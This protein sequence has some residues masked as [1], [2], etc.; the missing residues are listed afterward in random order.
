MATVGKRCLS[1]YL[2]TYFLQKKLEHTPSIV[3]KMTKIEVK[4][5]F[6]SD[7]LVK[8]SKMY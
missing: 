3:K 6:V 1:L 5:F 8:F 4:N 2:M 7:F